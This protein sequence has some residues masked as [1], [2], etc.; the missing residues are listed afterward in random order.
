MEDGETVDEALHRELGEEIGI[1]PVSYQQ[2]CSL[3]DHGPQE[4]GKATYHIHLIRTWTG[5]GPIMLNDEHTDLAWFSIEQACALSHLA[6]PQYVEMF[7]RI[8]V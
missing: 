4:R 8:S 2:L 3:M 6:L 7:R 1:I 5:D